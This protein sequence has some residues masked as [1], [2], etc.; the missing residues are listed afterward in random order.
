[1]RRLGVACAILILTL[2]LQTAASFAGTLQI[3]STYPEDGAT[4]MYPLNFAIKVHF[5]QDVSDARGMDVNNHF[6]I[7]GPMDPETNRVPTIVPTVLFDPKNPEMVLVVLNQDLEANTEYKLTI[8]GGFST[9]DGRS[10]EEDH[11]IRFTTRDMGRDM[12]TS[13]VMMILFLI[14]IVFVTTIQTKRKAKKDEEEKDKKAKVNPYKVSKQTGKSVAA[15]VEKDEK[16]KKKKA[17]EEAKLKAEEPEYED[18]YDDYDDDEYEDN[19]NYRVAGPKRIS[20]FSKY[21]SGKKAKAK[22]AAKKAEE[23]AR[24]KAA[25]GTTKPKNQT[26]KAK[27][28]KKK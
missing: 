18:D 15:I 4:G 21:K 9:P 2:L 27:N 25:A 19:D 12:N 8:S 16:E 17:A 14:V 28:K 11:V 6:V 10:L 13:M 3:V 26:G 23:E 20:P 22:A 1:M 5:G 24:K 7:T